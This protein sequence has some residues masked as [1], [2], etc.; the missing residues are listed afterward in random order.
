[1]K[2]KPK[3]AHKPILHTLI[4]GMTQ[5]G[6]TSYARA[7]VAQHAKRGGQSLVYDP[8]DPAQWENSHATS[9]IGKFLDLYWKSKNCLCVIDEA[10]SVGGVHDK[11]V[12][13]TA[14]RGRHRGHQNLYLA[15]RP[16]G[17]S[18]TIRDQCGVLVCFRIGYRDA[19]ELG[20]DWTRSVE[21]AA[22]LPLKEFFI[23]GRDGKIRKY[24]LNF[25][26]TKK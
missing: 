16:K 13:E 25:E 9:D 20:N 15:Q 12:I 10:L 14:T 7:Y 6:K 23:V 22:D 17:L 1:M 18:P 5:T 8:I 24:K 21:R 19:Y 26:R 11:D 4:L 2:P 3:T